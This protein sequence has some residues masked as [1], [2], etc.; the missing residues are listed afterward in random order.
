MKALQ[1][2]QYGGT[3]VLQW[4]DVERPSPGP[5]Q[6]V[7]AVHAASINPTEAKIRRGELHFPGPDQFPK[8]MGMDFAG[9]ITQVGEDVSQFKIG[10]SVMGYVGA[11]ASSLAE[12]T[13][14]DVQNTFLVPGNLSFAEATTLPMNAAT[15]LK[16]VNTYLKPMPGKTILVNGAAGGI[17]LFVV[18]YCRQ[19]GAVVTGTASGDEGLHTLESLGLDQVVDYKTTDI[20]QSGRTF[21]AILD[22]SGKLD[23]EQAKNSLTATGEF[24]TMA[25]KGDPRQPGRTDGNRKENLVFA[26]PGPD[27]FA[28][29]QA[30][31]AAGTIRT[32]VSQRF[33]MQDAIRAMQ[34]VESGQLA[35]VGK[36]VL[37]AE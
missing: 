23:F 32:F 28:A 30:M 9:I 17:G 33:P 11:N 22:M 13:L 5:D 7:V 16:V 4:H 3:D 18:Q 14:A 35:V 21:D 8:G 29:S 25:P 1:Y 15:A 27:E 24:S 2:N 37:V 36:V 19:A 20:W 34:L 6:V 31:A 26:V 10:D 12:F